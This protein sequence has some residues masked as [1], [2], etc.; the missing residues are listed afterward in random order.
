M[1]FWFFGL[2]VIFFDPYYDFV[3][4]EAGVKI[5][6]ELVSAFLYF[7]S[8]LSKE[9]GRIFPKTFTVLNFSTPF[10]FFQV[11]LFVNYG[12]RIRYPQAA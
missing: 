10:Y 8:A 7:T 3:H 4:G 5:F 1:S 2:F 12:L 9:L 11:T 6:V